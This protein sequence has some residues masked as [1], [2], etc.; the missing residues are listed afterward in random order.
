LSLKTGQKRQLWAKSF[1][2]FIKGTLSNLNYSD[3]LSMNKINCEACL[4]LGMDNVGEHIDTFFFGRGNPVMVRLC[5]NHS[6]ELFKFGQKHFISKYPTDIPD[7]V[8]D[9]GK[10]PER[11]KNYFVFNPR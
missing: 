7:R 1:I 10:S 6:I 5:Y 9:E 2:N 3:K 11:L 8:F 4:A